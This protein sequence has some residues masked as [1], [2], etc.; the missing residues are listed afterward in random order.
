[1]GGYVLAAVGIMGRI[2]GDLVYRVP[3]KLLVVIV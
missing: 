3:V 1:M 2:I